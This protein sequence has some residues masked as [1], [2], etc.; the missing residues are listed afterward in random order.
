MAPWRMSE[1]F[2]SFRQSR[3][4]TAAVLRS[5][6]RYGLGPAWLERAFKLALPDWLARRVSAFLPTYLWVLHK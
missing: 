4:V 5:C 3:D 6:A 2:A 1:L